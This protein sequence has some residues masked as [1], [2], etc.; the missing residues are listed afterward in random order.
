M[1]RIVFLFD[2]V[3]GSNLVKLKIKWEQVHLKTKCFYKKINQF[4]NLILLKIVTSKHC[5]TPYTSWNEKLHEK[6]KFI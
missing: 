1:I 3:L 4:F 2:R 6:K 5:Y